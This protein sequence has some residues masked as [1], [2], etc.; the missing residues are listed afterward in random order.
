MIKKSLPNETLKDQ[1]RDRAN[2][3]LHN[4]ML[5][6]GKVRG[7][8]LRGTRMV[9]EMRENHE[10]GI[11]ETLALGHAYL[12]A[13]LM[14]ANL[15]GFD[16]LSLQIE[17]SGPIEGLVA[18]TNAF[19]EVRGYLKQVPIPIEKPLA[20]FNLAPFFGAGFLSV[21][22][23]MVDAKHPFT[24]K[25]MMENGSVAKDLTLYY[26]KSEQL[27]TA[28]NLSIHFDTDG[29][30]TGAG[31][32]FLQAMPGVDDETLTAIETIVTKLPSLGIVFSEPRE[33]PAFIA[34]NFSAFSPKILDNRRVEFYCHCNKTTIREMIA[35]FPIDDLQEMATQGPF[36]LDIRCHH[37]NTVHQFDADDIQ[38]VY[39][40]LV[41]ENK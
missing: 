15:K 30:I 36:P 11:L 21:T 35:L 9:R 18:E 19:G 23:Y 31:G 32:L 34:E 1:L 25:V 13:G 28:F 14:S 10:L 22:K 17:C 41:N 24:G 7:V 26:L 38:G 5:V 16:R 2:D 8:I 40:A 33:V 39:Q 37:C 12:A 6:G 29:K 3:R 27:P 4:F 20:D